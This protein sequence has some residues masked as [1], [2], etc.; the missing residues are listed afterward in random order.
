MKVIISLILVLSFSTLFAQSSNPSLNKAMD[1]IKAG[2]YS[3]AI[4]PLSEISRDQWSKEEGETA[5]ALL[6]EAY[7]Q[8][9][10]FKKALTL[11]QRFLDTRPRSIYRDRVQTAGSI[12]K[13][14]LKDPYGAMTDLFMVL[15][16]SNNIDMRARAKESALKILST[17]VLTS[18]EINNLLDQNIND[19]H[20][21]AY[22]QWQLAQEYQKEGRYRGARALYNTVSQQLSGTPIESKAK[23]ALNELE[24]LGDGYPTII[25][26]APLSGDYAELGNR[27]IQGI[28]LAHEEYSKQN[29]KEKVLL[30]VFDDRADPVRAIQLV[31]DLVQKDRVIAVIGPLLSPGATALAA[32]LSAKHPEIAM[33]TP[34]ATDEGIA[35]LGG[36]IFQMNASNPSLASAIANHAL[37][38]LNARDFAILQ[39]VS[40]YGRIVAQAFARS[41]EAGGGKA[42]IIQPYV[43]GQ[44]EYKTEINRVRGAKYDLDQ[45]RDAYA[46]GKTEVASRPGH[47]KSYMTDS[48]ISYD[49]VFVAT[50]DAQEA[51]GMAS[52]I[53]FNRL[54]GVLLGSSGWYDPS[55]FN[56]G[57]RLVE[58]AYVSAPFADDANRSTYQ[59][60]AKSFA[61]R[62]NNASPDRD[63]V[64][65]LSYDAMRWTLQTWIK[66]PGKPLPM[67]LRAQKTLKGTLGD[68]EFEGGANTAKTIFKVQ[69][70]QF[71][72]LEGCTEP[73][74]PA[75]K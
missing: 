44:N 60:F 43:E 31:Q 7:L 70:S 54:G 6:V 4:N 45:S 51:A 13:A 65:A 39:P 38:C 49:A 48:L 33:I 10:D 2:N 56:D 20:I 63:R 71:I 53:A 72:P 59:S 12:A 24:G 34:T 37:H 50:S 36:N 73:P 46:K 55:L 26:L 58:G 61:S 17:P 40:L 68:Y 3:E 11:S 57:K 22:L 5:T 67:N 15:R 16:Y 30:Q 18:A 1:L 23:Q 62:W 41:V 74:P 27:M 52:H 28:V 42:H 19:S 14:Q 66:N 64:N 47:R 21:K 75:K 32:W 35:A 25:V 9:N 8:K 29:P 69:K